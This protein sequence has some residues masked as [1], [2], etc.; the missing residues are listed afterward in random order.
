MAMCIKCFRARGI[1]ARGR[2]DCSLCE[3]FK[4][5]WYQSGLCEMFRARGRV[6]YSLCEMFQGKWYQ[7]KRES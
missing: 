3:T 4:G 5:K 7:G 2:V 6:D 1:M